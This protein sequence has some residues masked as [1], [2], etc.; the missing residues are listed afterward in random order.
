MPNNTSQIRKAAV[1]LRSLDAD[2]ATT[3]LGQLS[4][5]EAEAVHAAIRS[6]GPMDLEEQADI[7][8]EFRRVAP[9]L[10]ANGV[11]L[12]LTAGVNELD[13]RDSRRFGFLED[14]PIESLVPCLAREHVQTIAVVLS[15]LRPARAAE[16]LAA[17]PSRLQVETIERLSVLGQTDP[18]SLTVLERELAA[19][20]A[21]QQTRQS[22]RARRTDT[23]AA[24]LT[25]TQQPTRRG[26]LDNLRQHNN[27][28]A[29]DIAR[30]LPRSA[31]GLSE[32]DVARLA[33]PQTASGATLTAVAAPP[34]KELPPARELRFDE[35]ARLGGDEL[36]A[37]LRDV[38]ANVLVLALAGSSEEMVDAVTG[39]MPRKIA[40]AFRRQLRHLGP[41]RLRDVEAAQATVAAAAARIVQP[42]RHLS[43]ICA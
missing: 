29:D 21:S 24:I 6:L 7:V 38:D 26:I 40:K 33:K 30:L 12:Q 43:G 8:A 10:A 36:S 23:V 37:V 19:W 14:A 5:E 17:L 32:A 9:T 22:R 39:R 28:L 16:V 3:L 18:D 15:H 13:H 42:R 11:E 27:R 31:G 25:A 34:T 1:L 2:T 20:L 41:T 4:A 35:L